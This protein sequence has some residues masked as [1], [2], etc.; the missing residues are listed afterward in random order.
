[1]T[2]AYKIVAAKAEGKKATRNAKA[3]MGGQ[4]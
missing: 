4:Y 1:V 2:N 3:Q